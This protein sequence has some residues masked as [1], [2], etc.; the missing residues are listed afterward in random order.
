MLVRRLSACTAVVLA[1]HAALLVAVSRHGGHGA[2]IQGGTT[3]DGRRLV[4][5]DAA[6]VAALASPPAPEPAASAGPPA[7][8]ASA[9]AEAEAPSSDAT[10]QVGILT[11]SAPGLGIYRPSAALDVPVRT[12]SAPDLSLLNGLT[13]SGLPLRI[14]LFIDANGKVVDVQ[15]L[16]SAE[17]P[18]VVERVRQMFLATG[19]TGGTEH[20]QPVPSFK[21]IEFN[22][23]KPA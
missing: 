10:K 11:A 14:R 5:L 9:P 3:H 22:V 1:A 2:V 23:G 12:R 8:D 19:F 21:D 4:V 20:G 13:W 7:S 15:V 18:E 6:R 17:E 16:A